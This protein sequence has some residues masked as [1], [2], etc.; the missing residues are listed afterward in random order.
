M[1]NIRKTVIDNIKELCII[2][3]IKQKD[4]ADHLCVSTGS[5]SNWFTCKNGIDI[6]NLHEIC[7]FLGVTLDQVAGFA[8]LVSGVLDEEESLLLVAYRNAGAETKTAIRKILDLPD[9]KDTSSKA[10]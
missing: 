9:K 4:I 7:V 8:P 2:K 3:N 10:E 6:D 5:V 1:T